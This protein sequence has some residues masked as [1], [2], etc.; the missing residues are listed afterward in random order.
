[1][2]YRFTMTAARLGSA[3]A[4]GTLAGSLFA[5]FFTIATTVEQPTNY[6]HGIPP[7]RSIRGNARA[8]AQLLLPREPSHALAER[9]MSHAECTPITLTSLIVR[10]EK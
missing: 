7:E 5:R 4:Y 6:E 3:T 2:V 1:M 10:L 8:L 9:A